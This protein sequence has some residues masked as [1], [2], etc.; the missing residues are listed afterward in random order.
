MFTLFDTHALSDK[1]TLNNRMVMAPMTR[2]R[3]TKGDIPNA[4]MA[5]YYA[6]RA[7]AGLLISE[8]VDVSPRGKGYAFTPGIYTEEQRQGWR[9]IT[10]AVHRQGGKIF[11]QLWHVGRMS[12][13]SMLPEGETPWGVTDEAADAEVFAHDAEG[14]LT[15]VRAGAP[16][17][18]TTEEVGMVVDEFRQASR[19]AGLTGFDGVELHAANGYLFDQFMNATLN[20]RDDQYGGQTPQSRTR[21]LLEVVDAAVAELGADRVGVRLSPFG[22]FN[23][24]P[25]DPVAE[26]TL[27]YLCEQLNRRHIAYIHLLYQ[28]MPIGNMETG[29]FKP[30][31]LS[32]E[33]VQKIRAAYHGTLIWCGGFDK[34]LAQAALE[35]GWTD[36]I[37]FGR[38]FVGNPDLVARY[39]ND[40]PVVEADRSTFYTRNGEKGFT[41]FPV[42]DP[43]AAVKQV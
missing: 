34:A 8:A 17:K 21:A 11:A 14:K 26:E 37:A 24:I 19:N 32:D 9:L 13:T 38:P 20:T 30:V 7:S 4:T 5:S 39:Q 29:E 2:T 28:F 42:Y 6:Q 22:R 25:A 10:D 33:L 15:F 18:I 27:L 23:G 41:D 16:R 36:L 1:L 3:T 12:H 43:S 40:W 31:N 35:T